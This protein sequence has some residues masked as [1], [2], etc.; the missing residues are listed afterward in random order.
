M[1]VQLTHNHRIITRHTLSLSGQHTY[2]SVD[3]GPNA[4]Y[5]GVA[6]EHSP[7]ASLR[8]VHLSDLH[9]FENTEPAYY[10]KVLADIVDAQPDVI[11]LTG[12][13]IHHGGGYVAMM[14]DWLKKLPHQAKK[15]AILGNH[16]YADG[17]DSYRVRQAL[18]DAGFTV[19]VNQSTAIEVAGIT[20]TVV[21][22]DDKYCGH[23]DVQQAFN[24]ITAE[25][26]HSVVTLIH[27][28]LLADDVAAHAP[29]APVLTLAGHTHAGHVYIPVLK[30]IYRYVL[31]HKYRYGFYPLNHRTGTTMPLYVTS[32]LGGAAYYI[33]F[34]QFKRALPRFRWNTHP[35]IAVFDL[36]HPD[37]A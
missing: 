37:K 35:E 27:N 16:D 18:V 9:F 8:I 7:Q 5:V 33:K 14:G 24:G 22:V 17:A 11:A 21:G 13:T 30:P 23:P 15:L 3:K 12:D 32:G 20:L 25:H 19:L 36:I 1:V 26:P 28:P 31:G 10:E 29:V 34:G 2:V 4:P 6:T